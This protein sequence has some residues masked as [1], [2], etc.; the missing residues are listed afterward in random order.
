MILI[1]SSYKV[2]S[3]LVVIYTSGWA[4]IL[5]V[6]CQLH[7]Q[8]LAPSNADVP[9]SKVASCNSEEE[10]LIQGLTWCNPLRVLVL[11]VNNGLGVTYGNGMSMSRI[12]SILQRVASP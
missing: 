11:T 3:I 10:S 2:S 5:R 7:K 8:F 6:R 4:S 1:N 9:Q 12:S